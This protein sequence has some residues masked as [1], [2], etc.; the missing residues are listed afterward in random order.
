MSRR[1]DA[2]SSFAFLARARA[3]ISGVMLAVSR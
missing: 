3:A 2:R 1:F